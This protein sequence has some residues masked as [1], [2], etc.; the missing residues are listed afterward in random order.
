MSNKTIVIKIGTN[1]LFEEDVLRDDVVDSLAVS[2]NQLRKEGINFAIVTSGAVQ[3]GANELNL[4]ERPKNLKEL[5]VASAVGQ[6]S[7]INKY[8]EI[9]LIN[10]YKEI[11][12]SHQLN[13]AQV[14]I[15]KNVLEDRN[16]FV[17]TTEAL[18]GLI[19][20]DIIPVINENDVVATEELKFGDND[21]LSA[22]VSI[23]LK[24][25]KLVV[26]TDKE[27]LF[28]SDPEKIEEAKKIE[29]I[30]YNSE[31]LND[32]IPKSSS[33]KGMGGFSTKIMAAQMAGFSGI[34]TQII[35]WSPNCINEVVKDSKI[36]TIIKPSKK[37]IKLRKLWIA[38]GMTID[39]EIVIDDGAI[40]A[41][42]A[43]ASL[44]SKGVINVNKSFDENSGVEVKSSENELI[45]RG[46][47]NFS[48]KEIQDLKETENTVVIHKDNLLIL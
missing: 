18:N 4:S 26:I 42:K 47:V 48:S 12:N 9:F 2:I 30:E 44:L 20:K 3:S 41:L 33:G 6:V 31:E 43:D 7:L 14:L 39:G 24:A 45:A 5:Q 10:K 40:E 46:V 13:I 28:D 17:N 32:L 34:E 27:G 19:S 35:S 16:Q 1:T 15:S 21:R 38:F 29:N 11:F 22:I 36:G 8:K 25:D 37:N 23:L